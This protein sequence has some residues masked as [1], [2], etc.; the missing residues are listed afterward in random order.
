MSSGVGLARAKRFASGRIVF[1]AQRDGNVSWVARPAAPLLLTS[2]RA[3]APWA[4]GAALHSVS[5]RSSGVVREVA[6]SVA[7]QVQGCLM[8]CGSRAATSVRT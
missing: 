8:G 1:H 4:A 3:P 5:R 6:V 2:H 7:V